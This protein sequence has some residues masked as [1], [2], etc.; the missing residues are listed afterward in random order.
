MKD[1]GIL[2]ILLK[3]CLANWINSI[4]DNFLKEKLGW[5][6]HLFCNLEFLHHTFWS[7]M[8]PRTPIDIVR[9]KLCGYAQGKQ[10]LFTRPILHP[11]RH[12]PPKCA[13]AP[14]GHRRN[15]AD[16]G[17]DQTKIRRVWQTEQRPNSDCHCWET[18]SLMSPCPITRAIFCPNLFLREI[19]WKKV[20]V[21]GLRKYFST[22][23]KI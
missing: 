2:S 14:K 23:F 8:E 5:M 13:R 4:Q 22:L 16:E 1:N 20:Q 21:G 10:T 17:P 15:A 9:N 19:W 3:K 7:F 12:T 18:L 11:F 6:K